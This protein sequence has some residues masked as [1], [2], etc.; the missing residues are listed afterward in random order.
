M[1]IGLIGY[2]SIGKRHISNL[3]S[4][5][6]W[7]ISLFREKGKGNQHGLKE[8][9]DFNEFISIDYDFII[10]SNITSLHF[11]YIKTLVQ[12]NLN[13]LVEKPIVSTLTE[14]FEL[15]Q[16]LP[17]YTG[18]GMVAYNTRFHPCVMEI[19]QIIEKDII[20]KPLYAR[21]F[22]GQYLPDWRPNFDYRESFS[23]KKSLGGGVASELI[24]EVDLAIELFG[25]PK[26]E[27]K[28]I[29]SKISELEIE[30][31][32]VADYLYISSNDVVISIH[33][34]YFYRGYKRQFEIVGSNANISCDLFSATIIV[35]GPENHKI[36]EKDFPS[37]QRNDMYMLLLQYYLGC[38]NN[39]VEPN[40]SLE[41]G[42]LSVEIVE[43]A[44]LNSAK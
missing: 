23:A 40:P 38:I 19:K 22:I 9:Y 6:Y 11:K 32:D 44:K 21:F 3:N 37:F 10:L 7:D 16:L 20:G 35:T 31:E 5:G 29:V 12:K 30:T 36:L 24:H 43:N 18:L 4:F 8:F 15:Q 28:S 1:K 25:K 27:I 13:I 34:D 33:T 2:G 42:L 39:K 17:H 26:G 41:N 14:L